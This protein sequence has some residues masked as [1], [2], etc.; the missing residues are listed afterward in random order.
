[1]PSLPGR[2]EEE[3]QEQGQ[4]AD[5]QS[6]GWLTSC[7]QG[8]AGIGCLFP[9][10]ALSWLEMVCWHGCRHRNPGNKL[11]FLRGKLFPAYW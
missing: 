9:P 1:M 5:P 11:V 4:R 3:Q 2:G 7:L 8:P 6:R 10:V